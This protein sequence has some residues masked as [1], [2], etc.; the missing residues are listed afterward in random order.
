MRG[1]SVQR[2]LT[3]RRRVMDMA[4]LNVSGIASESI[5]FRRETALLD[6]GR[7]IFEVPL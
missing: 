2:Y 5:D 4:S 1:E 3:P 6:S 7:K